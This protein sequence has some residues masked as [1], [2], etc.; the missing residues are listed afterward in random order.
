MSRLAP[1][2]RHRRRAL[3]RLALSIAAEIRADAALADEAKTLDRQRQDERSLATPCPNVAEAWFGA[4]RRRLGS[5]ADE[6]AERSRRLGALRAET[7][8]L[9]ARLRLFEEAEAEQRRAEQRAG[10]R[11]RQAALDELTAARWARR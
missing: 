2:I 4:A 5:I 3:D 1:A 10:E 8:A 6:R 9:R 11:R 7:L